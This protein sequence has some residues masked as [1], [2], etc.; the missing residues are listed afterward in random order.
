MDPPLF[1]TL[2]RHVRQGRHSLSV[3]QCHIEGGFECWLV[4]VR[5]CHSRPGGLELCGN[6]V[7]GVCKET[8]VLGI[9]AAT[10]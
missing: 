2:Q 3:Q 7:P 6:N 5:E 1:S 8:R 4:K 9:R 10:D